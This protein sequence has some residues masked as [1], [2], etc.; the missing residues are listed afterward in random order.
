[1]VSCCRL[2]H[3]LAR[4]IDRMNAVKNVS[5][6]CRSPPWHCSVMNIEYREWRPGAALHSVVLAYWRIAGDGTSVPNPAILPDAYI[7]IVLNLGG[8]V[9]LDG[10]P[11]TGT[12]PVRA[13][14]GLLES[15]IEMLYPQDVCT[16]GIRCH[17]ARASTFV[18][19][20]TRALMNTVTPLGQLSPELD[21]QLL[22]V[23]AT[24]PR[25]DSSEG[26]AAVEAVLIEH[27]RRG[28]PKDD[29]IVQ[30]VDHLLEADGHI[31]VSDLA[32]Q[33]GVSPR[34]LQRRF[35]GLFA[36]AT[37]NCRRD[38]QAMKTRGVVFDSE[39]ETMPYGTGVTLN[40]L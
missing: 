5:R 30:A 38:F 4:S 32:E 10:R 39:P 2:K 8:P 7:E 17:P 29:L 15:V 21:E 20:A 35:L 27:L 1:M 22:R 12:Q 11:F 33:L 26:L 9:T 25:V 36:L 37:D 18:G 14:V 13:V 6:A 23:T 31:A 28:T 16:F 19:V 34:H 24:N 40:V 3:E